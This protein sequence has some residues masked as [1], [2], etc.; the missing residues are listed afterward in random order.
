MAMFVHLTPESRLRL[1]RRSGISRL[2]KPIGGRPGGVF[3]VPVTRNFYV[4]HQWLRELKR[5]NAGPV[6]GVYFRIPDEEVVWVGH[7]GQAHRMMKAAEAVAMFLT[8]ENREGYEVIIPR[9]VGAS[10]I[11]RTRRL[12]QVVGWRYHPGSHGKKPCGCDFCQRGQYGARRL[13][14]EYDRG[15]RPAK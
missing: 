9:R 10:E 3:A 13:G 1:I 15:R 8:G 2:H 4:S 12:P 6:A 5:R 14:E 7:Y 11:H